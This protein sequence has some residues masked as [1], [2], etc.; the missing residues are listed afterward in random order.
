MRGKASPASI[1]QALAAVKLLSAQSG[2]RIDVKP[3]RLPRPGEPHALTPAEQ[4]RVERAAAR[5]GALDR[6]I[7]ATMLYAA[8]GWKSAPACNGP[9]RR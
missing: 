3:A 1:N 7:V 6:A 4:G 8:P 9:T 5:R 2:L